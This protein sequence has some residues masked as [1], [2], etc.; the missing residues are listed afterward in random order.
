[1]VLAALAT[2]TAIWTGTARAEGTSALNA[3]TALAQR[4]APDVAAETL[5]AI[6]GTESGFNRLA[7]H[8]N[9]ARTAVAAGSDAEAIGAASRLIAAGHSVD[10]GVM[11]INAANLQRLGLT[12][13]AAFDACRSIAAGAAILREGYSGDRTHDDQ[14]AALRVA[15]S[16][17]NTGDAVRGFANGFVG[18]VERSARLLVPALDIGQPPAAAVMPSQHEP[19]TDVPATDWEIWPDDMRTATTGGAPLSP[20]ECCETAIMADPG[21]GSAAPVLSYVTPLETEK[22]R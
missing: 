5:A 9:T 18:R 21:M 14:Q 4:C 7:I 13:Q 6:A 11:Q 19:K 22:E 12:V 17:Y 16:R 15:I 8:D 2:T 3:F 20:P 1:M 10:L